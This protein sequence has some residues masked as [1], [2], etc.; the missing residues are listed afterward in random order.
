MTFIDAVSG[1]VNRGCHDPPCANGSGL[2]DGGYER[3]ENF[4]KVLKVL[5]E[6]NGDPRVVRP[7]ETPTI[8]DPL[9]NYNSTSASESSV[10]GSNYTSDITTS[11]T[12][13]DGEVW[14]DNEENW[15]E[16]A[17]EDGGSSESINSTDVWVNNEEDWSNFT[18]DNGGTADNSTSS[19][20]TEGAYEKE[21]NWTSTEVGGSDTSSNLY[22][23]ESAFDATRN[24]GIESKA[25][26]DGICAEDGL[27]CYMV[28][29]LCGS[30]AGTADVEGT[31]LDTSPSPASI[32]DESGTSFPTY[33]NNSSST[34]SDTTS[35]INSGFDIKDTFFCGVDR[36]DAATSCSQRCRSG[37][38]GECPSGM[39]CF[40]Y[41]PCTTEVGSAESVPSLSE[42]NVGIIQNYCATSLDDLAVTCA[43]AVTCNDGEP[44]CPEGTYCWGDRMCGDAE[45]VD[46]G[47]AELSLAP[48][49][50]LTTQAP[51]QASVQAHV[52]ISL[53]PIAPSSIVQ[54]VTEE[55]TQPTE[56]LY[57]AATIAE[58]E[59]SCATAQSCTDGPCP[60]GSFCFPFECNFSQ[61]TSADGEEQTQQLY[62]AATMDELETSCATAQT[63]NDGPCPSGTFCFPFECGTLPATNQTSNQTQSS[64]QEPTGQPSINV[65]TVN[66]TENSG[67]ILCPPTY[68]GW[69]S[70]DCVEYWQCNDGSAG[71]ILACSGGEKFDKVTSECNLAELVNEFCYGP[72][73]T[74]EEEQAQTEPS[75][76]Q[77]ISTSDE[78][79]SQEESEICKGG[80]SGWE[81]GP[82]CRGMILHFCLLCLI[83]IL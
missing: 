39:S 30:S 74:A 19:N 6:E 21:E 10:T 50:S 35:T 60:S 18:L 59:I 37:V 16:P 64:V 45:A 3:S 1:I 25:C 46:D 56:Q 17:T 43:T 51:V 42:T 52:I 12:E 38:A 49:S 76:Q 80:R 13:E 63:C 34:I 28:S 44:D 40:G 65:A 73:P 66:S 78:E 22:C 77:G 11:G 23:G 54:N 71:P 31:T 82:G 41:T 57:C 29:G 81:A 69:L 20:T 15:S 33:A 8:G 2:L 4:K 9:D 75:P 67:E 70:M 7:S 36:A 53:S 83:S 48:S 47:D 32:S 62:C 27:N 72:A 58:L 61:V 68:T 24:C 55:Q 5:F 14:V 79:A 26:P